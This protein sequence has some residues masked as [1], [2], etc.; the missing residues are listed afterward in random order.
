MRRIGTLIA[1]VCAAGALLAPAAAQASHSQ[2]LTFEATSDLKDPATRD[3]AFKDIAAL[4]VHSMRLVL[5]WHDVA[6]QADSRVKPKSQLKRPGPRRM[7]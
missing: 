3:Q 5:Y 1:L 2:S 4:G 7:L 6:P